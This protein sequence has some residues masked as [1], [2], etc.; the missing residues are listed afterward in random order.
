MCT[1]NHE[2]GYQSA[3]IIGNNG[4]TYLMEC[5]ECGVTWREETEEAR[6]ERWEAEYQ[7]WGSE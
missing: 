1:K 4:E 3:K 2:N 6:E 7:H 5:R